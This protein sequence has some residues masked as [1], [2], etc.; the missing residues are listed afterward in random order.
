MWGQGAVGGRMKG[1]KATTKEE[2][3]EKKL[4]VGVAM[5]TIAISIAEDR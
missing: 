5:S 2:Q 1:S 3:E 4:L